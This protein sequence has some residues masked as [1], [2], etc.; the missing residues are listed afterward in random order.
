MSAVLESVVHL[1]ELSEAGWRNQAIDLIVISKLL[2]ANE[3]CD[4]KNLSRSLIA[5]LPTG[6]NSSDIERSIDRLSGRRTIQHLAAG[7]IKLSEEAR[8]EYSDLLKAH[9]ELEDRA[10]ERFRNLIAP[11][12]DDANLDWDSF[13]DQ[14][15]KPLTMTLGARTFEFLSGIAPLPQEAEAFIRYLDRV[16]EALRGKASQVIDAFLDPKDEVVRSYLLRLLNAV[17]LVHSTALSAA[18]VSAL[19][20]R[21]KGRLRLRVFVDTNFL[22]SLIGLHDNPADELVDVLR[23]VITEMKGRLDVHFYV[24]P[25]TVDEAR[26]TIASYA[27]NLSGIHVGSAVG[28]ALLQGTA[29]LSGIAMKY[30]RDASGS[31]L[32]ISSKE[33][34]KP[35]ID[36]FVAICRSKGVELYNEASDRLS[37]DQD[38]ID[39]V[40]DQQRFLKLHPERRQKSYEAILHDV[41]SWHFTSRK[42]TDRLESYLIPLP[43]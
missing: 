34:F 37:M 27:D 31:R 4:A 18:A 43:T 36:N 42:R 10:E 1:V 30:V 25:H 8:R 14:F 17:L 32:G 20:E 13:R 38:V 6:A 16:P 26:R 5:Q 2:E 33:Y 35:Y 7:G 29:D 15:L 9:N 11:L 24:L 41:I 23:Q 3:S 39:D 40:L 22:F 19:E 21:T 28:R 12:G